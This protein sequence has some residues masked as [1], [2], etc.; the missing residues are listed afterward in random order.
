LV[1]I[2]ANT[3]ARLDTELLLKLGDKKAD[4]GAEL[5]EAGSTLAHLCHTAKSVIGAYKA[6]RRGD[7]AGLA[8]SLGASP[9]NLR[10]GGTAA[11]RW[12]E[13]Q[14]AWLPMLGTIKDSADLISN[15][16]RDQKMLAKSARSLSDHTSGSDSVLA[17][18]RKWTSSRKDSAIVYYRVGDNVASTLHSLGLINPLSV[19][20]ELTPYSFL[21]DWFMPVGNFLEAL[22]ATLGV[23]FIDGCYV[24]K[25]DMS[26]TLSNMIYPSTF[27][28]QPEKVIANT[29]TVVTEA[30][31]YRRIRM[32]G[33]PVP[34]PYF[35]NPFSTK[36]VLSTLA[37]IRQ[38]KR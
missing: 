1:P 23:T 7:L 19:A 30:S 10:S 27:A 25:A 21:V 24:S 28:L 32:T 13:Y 8:R 34:K 31:S 16:F 12:L 5:G 3:K 2:D 9:K 4:Y 11:S 36:H 22:T 14:F 17:G 35:K 38:L 6:A 26:L 37:L 33:F 29:P 15:G 20:W 18:D